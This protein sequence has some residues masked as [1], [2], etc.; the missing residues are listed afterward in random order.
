MQSLQ[1]FLPLPDLRV[2]WSLISVMILP[3]RPSSLCSPMRYMSTPAQRGISLSLSKS[4]CNYDRRP[5]GR[6]LFI[7]Q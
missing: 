6:R 3:I 5:F 4:S 2:H 7:T 1:P